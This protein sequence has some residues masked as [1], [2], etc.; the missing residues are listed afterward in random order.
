MGL[1]SATTFGVLSYTA[2]ENLYS[3]DKAP[4]I[5]WHMGSDGDDGGVGGDNIYWV[6]TMCSVLSSYDVSWS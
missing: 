5:R 2:M 1:I 6:P 3:Q 4:S